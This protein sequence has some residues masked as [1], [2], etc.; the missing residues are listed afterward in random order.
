MVAAGRLFTFN[1]A[2]TYTYGQN[3][4][5][6]EPV[7]RI[8]PLFGR[9]SAEYARGRWDTGIEWMA[10]AKQTRL[11]AGDI[12]DNRIPEGGTPGWNVIN[13]N[14]SYSIGKVSLILSCNN[15]L[16]TD[17]RYHGSGVNGVGR[18]AILTISVNM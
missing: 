15:L 7:R 5:K 4:T 9:F 3:K 12:S 17:Y 18:S 10:A 6:N 8:P 14:A 2:L 11:A 1:T 16:N 13:L